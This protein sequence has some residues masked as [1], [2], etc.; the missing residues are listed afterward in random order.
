MTTSNLTLAEACRRTGKGPVHD[1]KEQIELFFEH[2]WILLV[3]IDRP[4]AIAARAM[5]FEHGLTSNDAFHLASAIR[6]GCDTLYT[7][8][9]HLL[10]LNSHIPGVSIRHP[11]WSGTNQM[12]PGLA[13]PQ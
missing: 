10:K 6:A 11:V 3:T 2:S 9:K 4:L 12:F 5:I 13:T 1:Q 8:D 7:Y